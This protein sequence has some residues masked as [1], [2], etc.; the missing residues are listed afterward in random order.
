MDPIRLSIER[1]LAT[2]MSLASLLLDLLWVPATLAALVE[3]WRCRVVGL[4]LKLRRLVW[5]LAGSI[6]SV[7]L[8]LPFSVCT[9]TLA[10]MAIVFTMLEASTQW[11]TLSTSS[12]CIYKSSNCKTQKCFYYSPLCECIISSNPE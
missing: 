4:V 7:V 12:C 5:C 10:T 6:V 3:Y 8:N 11:P 1:R 2:V 9:W